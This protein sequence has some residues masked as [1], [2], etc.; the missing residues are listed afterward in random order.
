MK[1]RI[2]LIVII[3]V[4][5]VLGVAIYFC[6]DPSTDDFFP[7]CIFKQLTG[8]DCPGCGSQRAI[9]CLLHGDIGGAWHFNPAV[10]V[11]IP[12]LVLCIYAEVRHKSCPRLFEWVNS[13]KMI[14]SIG[15]AIVLWWVLR[16]VF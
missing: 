11:A 1:R 3:V 13:V 14:N 5:V 12:I 16:N 8:F 4:A 6:Y 10:I 9:H 15:V 7:K 2:I